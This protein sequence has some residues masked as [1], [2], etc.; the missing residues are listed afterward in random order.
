ML[1]DLELVVD[2]DSELGGKWHESS[3]VAHL[4]D[5]VL[6]D[7]VIACEGDNPCDRHRDQQVEQASGANI[8]RAGGVGEV[9]GKQLGEPVANGQFRAVSPRTTWSESCTVRRGD[10][11]R[12]SCSHLIYQVLRERRSRNRLVSS[13]ICYGNPIICHFGTVTQETPRRAHDSLTPGVLN[14]FQPHQVQEDRA[15]GPIRSVALAGVAP[16]ESTG[17]RIGALG[18]GSR[19]ISLP[20]NSLSSN[21]FYVGSTLGFMESLPDRQIVERSFVS[22]ID[23]TREFYRAQGFDHP[24]RWASFDDVPF[25]RPVVPLEDS[26]VAIVTTSFLHHHDS[27]NGAPATGKVVYHHSTGV[28]PESM[29]TDDLSWD[30][31]AT[32][33]EDTESFLPIR[34]LRSLESKGEIGSLNH[35]FFGVPTQYSQRTTALDA[36]TIA[37]WC[38]DDDVDIALLVPL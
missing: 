28:A 2:Q 7:E 5:F 36:E 1:A 6:D 31:Q 26:N 17:L 16:I 38:V 13:A 3:V 20:T 19:V 32:H 24:Y 18:A 37:G 30:K 34:S 10:R 4:S 25:T 11:D 27:V 9:A 33:T 35:R 22:Y 14:D 15:S 23:K 21:S 8:G 12:R 29:F